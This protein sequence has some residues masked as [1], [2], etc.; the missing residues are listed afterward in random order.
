MRASTSRWASGCCCGPELWALW[1]AGARRPKPRIL[2]HL[3]ARHGGD[4][5]GGLR[6]QR[7]RRIRNVDPY[8]KRTKNRPLAARRSVR[9]KRWCCSSGSRP[10]ALYLALQLDFATLKLAFIGAALTDFVSLP[11]A[12]LPAAAV[13]SRPRLRMGRADG[14]HGGGRLAAAGWRGCCS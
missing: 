9:A 12:I 7:F 3:P 14:L 8:V 11:E 10:I 4:A 6:H 5:L 2:D 1:I 13:L